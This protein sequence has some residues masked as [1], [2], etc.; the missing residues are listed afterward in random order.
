VKCF[1]ILSRLHRLLPWELSVAKVYC[2]KSE[3]YGSEERESPDLLGIIRSSDGKEMCA[4]YSQEV[5]LVALSARTLWQP[6]LRRSDEGIYG[7]CQYNAENLW[8]LLK[9]WSGNPAA[10]HCASKLKLKWV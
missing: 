8:C 7:L 1:S 2:K 3:G 9:D 6:L 4:I 5:R 10:G